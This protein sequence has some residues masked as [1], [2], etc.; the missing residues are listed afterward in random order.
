MR[1]LS[2]GQRLISLFMAMALLVAVTGGFSAWSMKIVGDRIQGLLTNLSTV[3]KWVL[4][5][6]VAQK[7]CHINLLNA[8]M[9]SADLEKF[10]DSSQDYQAK[11]EL[12]E[13]QCETLLNGN[14]RLGIKPAAKGSIIEQKVKLTQRKWS[15]FEKIAD[16]LLEAKGRL[17]HAGKAGTRVALTE[18]MYRQCLDCAAAN[19]GTKTVVDDILVTVNKQMNEASAEVTHIQQ[20]AFWTSIVVVIAAILLAGLFGILM[21]RYIV[22]HI[23][24]MV[25]ALDQGAEGNLNVRVE[26]ESGDEFGKLGNNFN[27]MLGR[28]SEMMG[29]V[30]RSTREL[31]HVT[32]DLTEASKQVV[33]GAQLQADGIATTSSAVS[34][35][36]A[37]IKSVTHGVDSL[38]LS[39]TES[40]SSILE[41]AA[42]VE[43]VANNVEN[44]AHSVDE[45]SSSITEMAASIKQVGNGVM[46]LMDVATATASSVMEMDSS[47]KQVERNANETAAI[48]EAVA[49][50][51]ETGRKAVEAVIAGMQEIKRSSRHHL[52]R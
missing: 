36:N 52:A 43:E 24:R 32:D 8:V 4:L 47:I 39:A 23:S 7:D 31:I 18:Q 35:I 13:T 12:F 38:S 22:G 28:L 9:L 5:M 37:S 19:D 41:M 34:Q 3:Q 15:E 20:K 27:S 10:E 6:E 14:A 30:S 11:K 1:N 29:N 50:D 42:S 40:S 46:S 17:L 51:A 44:L 16:N 49:S 26:A 2:L 45:V 25:S 21:T 33:D 48:S